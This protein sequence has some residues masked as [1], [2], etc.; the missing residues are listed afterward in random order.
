MGTRVSTLRGRSLTLAA[1]GRGGRRPNGVSKENLPRKTCVVCQRPFTWRK[2]WERCWDEV[3]CCSDRCKNERK[4]S[5][6]Q[7]RRRQ[8][9]EECSNSGPDQR[10]TATTT[11]NHAPG[12]SGAAA[13]AV[14]ANVNARRQVRTLT[15]ARQVIKAARFL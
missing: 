13:A 7:T 2:K 12:A 11:R 10:T 5:M 9:S 3:L 1:R 6:K 8:A 15:C 4:R 14:K